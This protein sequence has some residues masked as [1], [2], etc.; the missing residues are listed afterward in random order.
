MY[1]AWDRHRGGDV[2]IERQMPFPAEEIS[3]VALS[4]SQEFINDISNFFTAIPSEKRGMRVR[5]AGVFGG[6]P[7]N[8]SET[9]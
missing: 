6:Y 1:L 9:I 2:E 4:L 3:F 8:W 7:R 5:I